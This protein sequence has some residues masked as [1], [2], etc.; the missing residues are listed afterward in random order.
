MLNSS[1]SIFPVFLGGLCFTLTRIPASLP[2][3]FQVPAIAFHPPFGLP[4]SS[5][6]RDEGGS[7]DSRPRRVL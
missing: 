6:S 4:H 1:Y 2:R 5:R 3:S 7:G